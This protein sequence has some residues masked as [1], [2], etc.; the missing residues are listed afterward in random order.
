MC[1]RHGWAIAAFDAAGK[2]EATAKGRPPAW[3]AGILRTEFWGL[4]MSSFSSMPNAPIRVDSLSV[5]KGAP[6][7]KVWAG[8]IDR[9]LARSWCPL[10]ST[11]KEPDRVVRM[12]AHCSSKHIGVKILGDGAKLSTLDVLGNALVDQL[13]KEPAQADRVPL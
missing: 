4:L 12:P 13:A 9:W 8:A 3:A 11:L 10:A 2:L 6:R 5:Q 7:G 1:A